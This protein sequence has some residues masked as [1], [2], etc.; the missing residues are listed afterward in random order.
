VALP[1]L[2]LKR[3]AWL[4]AGL[5]LLVLVGRDFALATTFL[6]DDHVFR[7]FARLEPNPLVAFVADKHGGEYY[8]PIPM[9]LWWVLERLGGGRP[10]PF[11]LSAFLLH[12]ACALLLAVV[13]HRLGVSRRAAGLAGAL[14]FVAPAEREA[15]LWFSASTDLIATAA[16]LGSI[17]GL[18]SG[19]RMG[20][21]TSLSLAGIAFF[22]KETALVLP[23]VVASV[24]WYRQGSRDRQQGWRTSLRQM[25]TST[26]PYVAVAVL[27]LAARWWVLRGPGGSND[28]RAPLW[29]V[30][31]QILG[32]WF[33]AV[34]AYAPLPE[35]VAWLLGGSVLVAVGIVL[36]RSRLAWM[37]A[38]WAVIAVLPL[39]AAGW[40]VGAR[41][42]YFAATGLMLLLALALE[43]SRPWLPALGMAVLLCIGVVAGSR[44]I[45]DI[46]R[47][48][49][50]VAAAR[51]A[52]VDG[53]AKGRRLFLVRGSVKDLD[54]AI[55]LDPE[56]PAEARDAVAIPDVPA[57]F[58]WLPPAQADRLRFLFADPPLPPAGAYRF[59]GERIVGLARREDAPDLDEV[60]SRLPDLRIIRLKPDAGLVA[61]E[62]CTAQYLAR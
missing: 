32:G 36:R 18:L 51:D 35:S 10:W 12:G 26:V 16:M 3:A 47:Y 9:L 17:A 45:E 41:Y 6:G 20:R 48:R 34:S 38:L 2:H 57:S 25:A 50:V 27:Y 29:A 53:T 42:F 8:R 58:V 62:D 15:A 54:L 11:A 13:A 59:G 55:K 40:V 49:R 52:V 28:P 31:I 44:R 14:L 60:L 30:G 19:R 23:L 37:A 61:W 4:G 33:H 5:V 46:R 24:S 21:A 56:V 43:R 22:S 39:P 1:D 7:A